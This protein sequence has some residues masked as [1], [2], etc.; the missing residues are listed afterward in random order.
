MTLPLFYEHEAVASGVVG[1]IWVATVVYASVGGVVMIGKRQL[2]ALRD[3]AQDLS[4]RD[5][6]TGLANRRALDEL[7]EGHDAE[8]RHKESLGFLLID[9]DNFK[10]VNTRFGMEGGDLTLCTV[11]GALQAIARDDQL[12]VRIG[13]DEFAIVAQSL[14]PQAMERLADRSLE[15]V[16]QSLIDVEL[17]GLHVSA[18]AGSA[19]PS[20]CGHRRGADRRRGPRAAGREAGRKEQARGPVSWAGQAKLARSS[21]M[22]GASRRNSPR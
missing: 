16:R 13:G 18:S 4:L 20:R 17:P 21:A 9:I 19:V 11:A 1:Q 2:L 10:E 7:L 3:A 5:S 12:V 14:P 6:L 22:C 8:T 15:A